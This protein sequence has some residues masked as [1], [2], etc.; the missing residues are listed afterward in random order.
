VGIDIKWGRKGGIV[1]AMLVGFV[2]DDNAGLFERMLESGVDPSDQALILDFEQVTSFNGAG[3]RVVLTF[4][5]KFNERGR[6]SAICALQE[7]VRGVFKLSGFDRI[8]PVYDSQEAAVEAFEK[9]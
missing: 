1:I 9:D 6:R 4:A 2:S 5:R 7:R 8:I 3:M